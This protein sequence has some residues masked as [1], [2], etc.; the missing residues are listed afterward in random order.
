VVRIEAEGA[1]KTV[2][3]MGGLLASQTNNNVNF[4]LLEE[5]MDW[6]AAQLVS[7]PVLTL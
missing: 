6:V 4:R 7:G 1:H 5:C 2:I 3:T